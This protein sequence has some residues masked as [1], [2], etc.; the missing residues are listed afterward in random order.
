MSVFT[1]ASLPV[2]VPLAVVVVVVGCDPGAGGTIE[3][4]ARCGEGES[5]RD[6]RRGPDFYSVGRRERRATVRNRYRTATK[7]HYLL[8][9]RGVEGGGVWESKALQG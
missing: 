2:E 1:R 4:G 6:L 5:G 3:G 8:N 7:F 9:W